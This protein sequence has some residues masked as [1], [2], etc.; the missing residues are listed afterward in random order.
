MKE[1]LTKERIIFQYKNKEKI[2]ER[3][4]A[5]KERINKR[6]K[7]L[8]LKNPRYKDK[9]MDWHYRHKYGISLREKEKMWKQQRKCPICQKKILTIKMAHVDHDHTT[10]AIRGL[11]CTNCNMGLGNFKDNQS[12]LVAAAQ[13]LSDSN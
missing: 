12:Y 4:L 11:L 8:Y 2:K 13:Y 3:Y 7:E 1:L 6:R 10:G 5:N 9:K